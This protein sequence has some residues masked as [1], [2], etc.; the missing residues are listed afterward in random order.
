MIYCFGEILWDVLPQKA[1]PGGALMN[2]CIHLHK[3]G[4]QTKLISA[5]GNDKAGADLKKYLYQELN[6]VSLIQTKNHLA[7][8]KVLV[9]LDDPLNAKYDILQPVAYDEIDSPE[10]ALKNDDILV[11]GS[12]ASR[13]AYTKNTLLKLLEK[14]CLKVFDINLRAPHY[15]EASLKE[16]LK[17]ADWVKLNDDEFELV[18]SW[19][20]LNPQDEFV[21]QKL[22]ALW[23]VTLICL[24][25]GGKG[26]TLFIDDQI[27]QHPGFKVEVADTVGAGDAFLA[28][29]IHSYQIGCVPDMM[30]NN[31]CALGAFVAGKSGANPPYKVDEISFF[32]N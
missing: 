27:Y 30:L 18:C 11:F 14:P 17:L 21:F 9:N 16:F 29:L 3:L 23:D 20:Q 4:S 10:I 32:N 22:A 6:D 28:A 19:Y 8:G 15:T 24:T 13:G 5:I 7:T 2:V 25:K 31:A 12:L 26:A 1:L